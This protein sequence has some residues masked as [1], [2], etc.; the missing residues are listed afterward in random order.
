MTLLRRSIFC[1]LLVLLTATASMAQ[2]TAQLSGTVTDPSGGVLPGAAVMAT[3]TDIGFKR[4]VVTD[5]DGFFSLPGIPV[6]PYKLE[7]TLQ[8]FR[9]SVQTGIVLQ[10]NDNQQVPIVLPLGDVAETITV[11]AATQLVETRNLGVSE[12]MDSKR[13]VELPLNGR[14]P[15]DLLQYLPAVVPQI[16]Q[17]PATVMGGS[18]GAASYSLAGGLAFGVTYTLDG[19][20]HN[21]PRNNLNLPLPFPDALQE[22][23]TETNALTARN[24]MHSSGAVS[25]VT[26]SGTNSFH[27]AAFEFLRHHSFNATDPFATKGPDGR[28]KDD[29]QKRNQYGV[30]IGG[31]IK[32][33]RLFFFFGYQ[34][35]NTRVNPTDNRAFVP[36]EAMLTG[37]FTAFASPAC[38]AGVQRNLPFPFAG[39]RIDPALFSKAALNITSK[40][41][42]TTDPCGLL[43]YGLPSSQDESQYVTKIDYTLNR[44]HSMF[45]RYITTTQ[46]APPPFT[47]ES[48]QGNVLTTRIGGRDN[49]AHSVTLGENYV[50]SSSTLNSVRFAFNRTHI[51]RP[52]IDFFSPQEVGINIFSYLPHYM[53]LNVIGGFTLGTGTE[54][55]TEIVTPSWQMSDD[56]TL[57]RGGH[58]YV[59]GGT[60]ARWGTE[61]LGNVRSPG[62]L[63]IDGTV[64]GMGLA[65]FMLGR[66]GT[67]ALV[68]AAPNAL[69]MQQTYLG[70]YVQDTWRIGSRLTLNYGVR[71]E[72]FF[73]QQ[74]QNGAVYQFDMDRFTAGTKSTVFPNAPAGLYFPGDAGFPTQ[75]GM[76][77]D[78]KNIGPR[79]GVAW[80]PVGDGRTSVRASYG[81]SFEFVD[82]QFHLNTSVAPPWGSE[83]RLNAPPGGLD[84]PFLG[85]PG[86]QT[87]I[88][89][90]TF[91]QNA[92]FSLNGPFLSLTNDLDATNVQLFNVTVER[93]FAARWFATAGYI[94]SRTHD[95]WESTPLNNAL[96]I[97]VAGA[98][99]SVANTNGRRPLTL[100]DPNNGRYYGPL[101]KYVS[102]GTQSYN[103][104]V[105]AI[106]GGIPSAMVNANYTL[107]HCYGSPDGGGS[108]TPNVSTGYNIPSDPH[109]DDGNCTVDRLHNF[110]MTASVQSPELQHALLRGAF[111]DWRLVA[112]FRK[113]TGPWLTV[114]TGTD[115]ALNGQVTTQRANQVLDDPYADR[116]INPLN[117]GMRFLNP[118]AF[119]L[120]ASGTLG[121]SKRNGIRGMGTR[122]LD[123]SLTRIVRVAGTREFELRVDAFNAFN[124]LQWNQPATALNN[125]GTF[126]QI[127]TA[128][129]PRIM[130]FAIKYR[131]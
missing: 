65:D 95:I 125:P 90:V 55:P 108:S 29:G 61:S 75:A 113:T 73:P 11:E 12:V 96:L 5:A 105:L 100:V 38:N 119:A 107:S 89:P 123:L 94:G 131:F 72:P 79:V 116:S 26:R 53:L 74:I 99:P 10:V 92:P 28:R 2:A 21:D 71:W 106:R 17:L 85:S 81:K 122:N 78:W 24:G 3:Q 77:A 64:T 130:Q 4:E 129:P 110:S 23:Q 34:G 83:V 49:I 103:G 86:G 18:N 40:L 19:A 101:D 36:T 22:F 87:N 51:S 104:M 48:A 47:L 39:N 31:P 14:N 57:V 9:T 120:P 98:A 76:P 97:P 80:D 124:W 50:I 82:G 42:K 44:A 32:T 126:G 43:Q 27:G 35:T 84:N 15:V 128:G 109:F 54:T 30:T 6:G 70:L 59:I 66:M 117:G 45:G 8:G 112:G 37:D 88:F 60:F 102:D 127:T 58:Q 115:V 67:N 63:T 46:E 52:N 16:V 111:S 62:Q 118:A 25:A 33:D 20:M 7:V 114:T 91:D 41:P 68:Q 13:I 1:G 93:Q 121:N 56:L 69:D